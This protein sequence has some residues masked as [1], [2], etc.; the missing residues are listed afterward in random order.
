MWWYMAVKT[1]PKAGRWRVQSQLG[2]HNESPPQEKK[3]EYRISKG[4]TQRKILANVPLNSWENRN[5]NGG[6][7]LL[8]GS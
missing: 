3:I 6:Q 4:L 7:L 1:E 8:R 5:H 2:L